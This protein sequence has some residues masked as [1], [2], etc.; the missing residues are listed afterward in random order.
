MVLQMGLETHIPV[1]MLMGGG[2]AS[3]IEDTVKA[4]VQSYRIARQVFSSL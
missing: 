4:H 1:V 2:Y 3:P